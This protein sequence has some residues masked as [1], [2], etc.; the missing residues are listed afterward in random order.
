MGPRYHGQNWL[1]GLY[2]A[3]DG[4][5]ARPFH[6]L[7]LV[8]RLSHV[9]GEA[10]KDVLRAYFKRQVFEEPPKAAA[11]LPEL[12]EEGKRVKMYD[13]AVEELL[14]GM[15]KSG[16][17]FVRAPPEPYPFHDKPLVVVSVPLSRV[18]CGYGDRFVPKA[19]LRR[20]YEHWSKRLSLEFGPDLWPDADSDSD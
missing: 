17:P 14:D 19:I 20:Y 9:Y 18:I 10:F 11:Y 16:S 12:D 5:R 15:L 4:T 2:N 1:N 7:L 8:Y 13:F 6:A 3:C